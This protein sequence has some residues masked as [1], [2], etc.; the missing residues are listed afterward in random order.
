MKFRTV[1]IHGD[2]QSVKGF[3]HRSICLDHTDAGNSLAILDETF[4]QKRLASCVMD[5]MNSHWAHLE[6]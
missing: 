4:D 1:T 3:D 6:P 2:K 5:A